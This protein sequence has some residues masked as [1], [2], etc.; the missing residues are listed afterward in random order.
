M[1][2]CVSIG[3]KNYTLYILPINHIT[4]NF[5][6]IKNSIDQYCNK[7]TKVSSIDGLSLNH[8]SKHSKKNCE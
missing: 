1:R 2:I 3:D 4:S 5:T 6:L 8:E 7:Q